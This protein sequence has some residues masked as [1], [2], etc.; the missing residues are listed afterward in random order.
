M[1]T[2]GRPKLKSAN[3]IEIRNRKIC[4]GTGLSTSDSE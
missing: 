1:K 3:N 4:L 2:L